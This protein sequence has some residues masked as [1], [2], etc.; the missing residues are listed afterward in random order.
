VDFDVPD[1]LKVQEES[2]GEQE[3]RVQREPPVGGEDKTGGRMPRVRQMMAV[4]DVQSKNE[5]VSDGRKR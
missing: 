3:E 2:Q 5:R 4:S 1:A